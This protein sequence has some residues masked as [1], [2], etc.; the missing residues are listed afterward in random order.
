MMRICN[1]ALQGLIHGNSCQIPDVQTGAASLVITGP[2]Y[3]PE[4]IEKQLLDGISL[5]M[6][7]QDLVN[8][9]TD[10]AWSL[11]SAF[12]E[13]FRVSAPGAHL[14]VQ[15]RDVRL[16]DRLVSVEAIHRELAEVS[17]FRLFTRHIWTSQH[18]TLARRRLFNSLLKSH[19]PCPNDPEIFLVFVKPGTPIMGDPTD[20]DIELLQ[21]SIMRTSMGKV[22]E[23]HRHQSP[24]PVVDAFI[25]TYTKAGDLVIDPFAGGGTIL[26]RALN[27]GRSAFGIEINSETFSLAQRNLSNGNTHD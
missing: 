19:G 17:G 27:L 4:G 3:F 25:R 23:R 6:D 7:T 9:T 12:E 22:P 15:T 1:S 16:R 20:A 5:G 21:L 10:F 18:F 11:R 14:V 26:L 13:C 2:P 24:V 8:K